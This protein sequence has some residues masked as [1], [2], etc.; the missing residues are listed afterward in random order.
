MLLYM[1]RPL[2]NMSFTAVRSFPGPPN[3]GEVPVLRVP[4]TPVLYSIYLT[5]GDV[6]PHLLVSPSRL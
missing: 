1:L 3:L 2:L 5:Q 6:L 4:I